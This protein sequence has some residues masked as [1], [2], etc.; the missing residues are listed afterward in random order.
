MSK[1]RKIGIS[2][3]I[4][5]AIVLAITGIFWTIG[6]IQEFG[7]IHPFALGIIF[8]IVV[9]IALTIGVAFFIAWFQQWRNER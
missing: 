2:S 4:F 3:G 7:V 6:K 9:G 8:G 5:I 1:K